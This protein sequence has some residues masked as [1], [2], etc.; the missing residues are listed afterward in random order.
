V[1]LLPEMKMPLA[2]QLL[3]TKPLS[4]FPE[5]ETLMQLSAPIDEPLISILGVAG[6][7]AVAVADP[8]WV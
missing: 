2:V 8:V 7:V 5:E 4:R 6:V 1:A 3:T